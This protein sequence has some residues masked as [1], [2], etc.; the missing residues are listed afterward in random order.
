MKLREIS[1]SY[2]LDQ[3]F[4]RRVI[5]SGLEL[6][7]TG[8]NLYVWSDYSGFDPE[9]NVFGQNP[10]RVGSTAADRG[11]DFGS[12]PIPRAWSLAARFTY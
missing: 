2:T 6:T 11:F 5:P 7:L 1:A 12:Y 4:V 10:E 3:P 8:R 9:V